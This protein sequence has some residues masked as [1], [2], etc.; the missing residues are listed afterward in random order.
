M[1]LTEA[2]EED[3]PHLRERWYRLAAANEPYSRFNELVYDA[4]AEVPTEGFESLLASE[5]TTVLLVEH[6]G[7]S[8]GFCTLREGEHPSRVYDHYLTIM[9]LFIAEP[10]RNQGH[11]AAVVDAVRKIARERGCDHLTVSCEWEN[12]GARR[13]Y[14]ETGFEEKQVTFVQAVE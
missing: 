7:D 12:V 9:D 2:T 8:I 11:G 5:D 3:V 14:R 13:F 6:D 10:H 1:Q 4:P